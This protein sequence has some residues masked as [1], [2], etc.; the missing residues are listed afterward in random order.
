MPGINSI[1][2][3]TLFT[4]LQN[5]QVHERWQCC[6]VNEPRELWRGLMF[7]VVAPLV[8]NATTLTEAAL[9]INKNLWGLWQPTVPWTWDPPVNSGTVPIQVIFT[10]P[11]FWTDSHVYMFALGLISHGC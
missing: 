3:Y 1:L 2:H 6:S 11:S 4:P 10:Y 7:T 8:A 5:L 9:L